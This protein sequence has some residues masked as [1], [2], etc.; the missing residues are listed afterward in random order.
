ME[1][2]RINQNDIPVLA[3]AMTAAYSEEPWNENWTQ[4]KAE[5]RIRAILGNFEAGSWKA[6]TGRTGKGAQ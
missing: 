1:I 5:R 6:A 4:E 2:K 3:V